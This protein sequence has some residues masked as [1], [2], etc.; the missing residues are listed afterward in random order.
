LQ[1]NINATTSETYWA[2]GLS[3]WAIDCVNRGYKVETL[4]Y[5]GTISYGNTSN[6]YDL[7]N[8]KVFIVCEPNILFTSSEKTAILNFI[9]AGGSL[10][11]ISNHDVSDRN[12]D[13]YDSPHIWNDLM[14]NNSTGNNNPFGIIYDY[15]NI[16]TNPASTYIGPLAVNDSLI[17]GPFGKVTRLKYSAGA[18]MNLSPSNNSTVRA[19]FYSQLPSSGNNNVMAAYSR[20]GNG[21][22]VALG[23]SSPFDD[24]TGDPNDNLF[25]GYTGD[26][27]PDHRNLIMNSTIWLASFNAS[28]DLNNWTGAIS[29]AWENPYNWSCGT[30][31]GANT[32][33][34][35]DAGKP[36]YPV[37]GSNAICKSMYNSSGTSIKILAGFR[38]DVV[39]R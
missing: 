9:R 11:M 28:C 6:L 21:R 30:I 36:N 1:A 35:I 19:I 25:N 34:R 16:I 32:E 17:N 10:F 33:V 27:P 31:P 38:L 13:G 5:N 37:V 2:G 3:H 20:Y 22:V 15:V 14:Q 29:T 7:S 12:N 26:A 23:D 8:Y 18:T 4:P 24:G 39:G